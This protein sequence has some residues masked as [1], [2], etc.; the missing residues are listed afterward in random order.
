MQ[1]MWVM[2]VALAFFGIGCDQWFVEAAER[3]R[4]CPLRF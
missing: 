4:A 1:L 3:A 2:I